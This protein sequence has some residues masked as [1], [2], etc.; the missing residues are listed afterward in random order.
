MPFLL[1]ALPFLELM[2]LIELGSAIGSFNTIAYVILTAILGTALL[3]RQGIAI[4]QKMHQARASALG[5]S[6]QW[7]RDEFAISLSAMLLMIPGLVTDLLA[8]IV[9]IGP[10]RRSC[11]QIFGF[12]PTT[13]PPEPSRPRDRQILEGE[14][15]V[16]ESSKEP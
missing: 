2:T 8:L 16:K 11:L 5:A 13:P 6:Q 7:F 3:K 10:L 4:L 14:Y 1:L 15:E 12:A 9:A